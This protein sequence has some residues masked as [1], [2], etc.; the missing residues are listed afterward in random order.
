[1]RES[2]RDNGTFIVGPSTPGLPAG[3]FAGYIDREPS[4]S[5][6]YHSPFPHIQIVYEMT[7]CVISIERSHHPEVFAADDPRNMM[8]VDITALVTE[9]IVSY[10]QC[11]IPDALVCES[12]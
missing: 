1:M 12:R 7:R 4:A 9:G 5:L 6:D 8:D 10:N 11:A 2:M 3:K